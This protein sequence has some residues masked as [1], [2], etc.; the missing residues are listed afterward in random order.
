MKKLG[1][2]SVSFNGCP[3]SKFESL[4][5]YVRMSRFS[6]KGTSLKLS[7]SNLNWLF[8]PLQMEKSNQTVKKRH[9]YR[10]RKKK[11]LPFKG[12]WRKFVQGACNSDIFVCILNVLP[13]CSKSCLSYKHPGKFGVNNGWRSYLHAPSCTFRSTLFAQFRIKKWELVSVVQCMFTKT[14]PS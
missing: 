5:K 14:K 7:L 10:A 3:T 6:K 9:G 11:I 4:L 2:Q 12:S 8:T 1:T 13:L